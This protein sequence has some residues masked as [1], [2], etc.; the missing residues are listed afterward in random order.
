MKVYLTPRARTDI[1]D[2][3]EYIAADSPIHAGRLVSQLLLKASEL[4]RFPQI[5]RVI[6]KYN[7]P[8]LR[9][10]LYRDYRIAYRVKANVI[11]VLTIRH[12]A[13]LSEN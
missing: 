6:A 11:E 1:A 4:G 5:G 10:R 7:N 8:D 13:R 2:I 9:E 12:V 3:Y